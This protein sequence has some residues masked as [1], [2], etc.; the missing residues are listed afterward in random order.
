MGNEIYPGPKFTFSPGK[1][2]DFVSV[3]LSFHFFICD[4]GIKG[5]TA[6]GRVF[7]AVNHQVAINY[8]ENTK[9]NSRL[10]CF[11]NYWTYFIFKIIVILL[12]TPPSNTVPC[13]QQA[14][15]GC[16][17]GWIGGQMDGLMDAVSLLLAVN[18]NIITILGWYI[19]PK[20]QTKTTSSKQEIII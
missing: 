6:H 16:G 7:Q 1:A 4:T 3:T 9:A 10:R 2:Y 14:H 15:W 8:S 20:R 5:D 13:P 11:S 12:T 17:G 19:C 18:N